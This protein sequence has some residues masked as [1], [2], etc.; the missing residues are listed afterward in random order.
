MASPCLHF[1]LK[2]VGQQRFP[3]DDTDVTEPTCCRRPSLAF[4]ILSPVSA[5]SSPCADTALEY[6]GISGLGCPT[7]ILPEYPYFVL[8]L[9]G[10]RVTSHI[11]LISALGSWQADSLPQGH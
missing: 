8:K 5:N 7:T 4:A 1:S 6:E 10:I 11:L 9:V 3:G 2:G